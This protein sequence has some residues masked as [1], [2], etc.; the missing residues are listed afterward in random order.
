M[1]D[2][3]PLERLCASNGPL[4][5]EPADANEFAAL[6]RSGRAR[7]TDAARE[8]ISME[9][10]FDLAYNAAHALSLAALRHAGYRPN[11]QRYVVFQTLEH[12]LGL[13]PRGW[14]GQSPPHDGR[15][16]DGKGGRPAPDRRRR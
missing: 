6:L 13:G 15:D 8:D 7:L 1:S 4:T 16:R 3:S 10:R 14:R 11:R 9:S 5:K 12:K 2:P